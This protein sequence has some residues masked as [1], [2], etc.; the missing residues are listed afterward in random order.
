M[1][2][3]G[4]TVNNLLL[5]LL[6]LLPKVDREM[7]SYSGERQGKRDEAGRA[8]GEE[9]GSQQGERANIFIGKHKLQSFL[10]TPDL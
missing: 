3:N 8:K 9:T 4:V 2:S 7:T 6:L 10:Y 5:P 1:Q